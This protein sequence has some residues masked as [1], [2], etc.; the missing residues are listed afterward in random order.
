MPSSN[1]PPPYRT[2][3]AACARST[4]SSS[5]LRLPKRDGL[6]LRWRSANPSHSGPQTAA[7]AAVTASTSS[8]EWMGAS[9]LNRP[10]CP[11]SASRAG[12]SS[13][14]SSSTAS[15]ERLAHQPVLHRVR[16]VVDGRPL[17]E[18]L[19]VERAHAAGGGDLAA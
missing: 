14:G 7:T 12:P 10:S 1:W 13:A 11:R 2:M 16:R 9:K 17:V 18:R 6:M 3:P 5:A 4:Q 15:G 8:Q 19:E